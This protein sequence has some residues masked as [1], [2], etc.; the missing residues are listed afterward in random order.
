[1]IVTKNF[2]EIV[3]GTTVAVLIVTIASLAMGITMAIVIAEGITGASAGKEPA[4]N[5]NDI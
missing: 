1:M 3:T 5:R 2:E 4:L